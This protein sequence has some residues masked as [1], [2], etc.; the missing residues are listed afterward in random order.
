MNMPFM[1][2]NIPLIISY[3]K[4]SK[5]PIVV[6]SVI[7]VAYYYSF[8]QNYLPIILLEYLLYYLFYLKLFKEFKVHDFILIF[9]TI[10][11]VITLI[12]LSYQ[13]YVFPV[14][15]SEI[16]IEG[17][18]LYAVANIIIYFLNKTEDVLKL[19]MN[20][21]EIKHN[22]QIHTSLFQ[23][24]HEIKNPIA[25]CKGYLDMF[26]SENP[27]HFKKYIPILKIQCYTI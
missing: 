7:M 1:I 21:K 11:V 9:T 15:V 8:Y 26:D 14:Y 19:H 23:I 24:T 5:V 20:I 16:I 27:K 10:K 25:V 6:T 22:E 13:N 2:I 12:L 18:Y 17:I 4:K 3:I